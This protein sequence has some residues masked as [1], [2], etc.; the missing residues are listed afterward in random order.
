VHS[1]PLGLLNT[2]VCKP[3]SP[4]GWI[5]VGF[6]AAAKRL[7]EH[8]KRENKLEQGRNKRGAA[9]MWGKKSKRPAR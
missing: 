4:P 2:T 8:N 1:K 9:F 7:L 6:N 3:P 5:R